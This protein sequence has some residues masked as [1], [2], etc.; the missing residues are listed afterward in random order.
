MAL[1]WLLGISCLRRG[2]HGC[3]C[4]ICRRVW[5]RRAVVGSGVVGSIFDSAKCCCCCVGCGVGD[6]AVVSGVVGVAV[7]GVVR[8]D[9]EDE[10]VVG[11]L[12]GGRSCVGDREAEKTASDA[13][14]AGRR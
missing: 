6:G 14:S 7:G 2:R 4:A 11:D 10:G 5:F 12:W 8:D 3:G 1:M 13:S 9:E